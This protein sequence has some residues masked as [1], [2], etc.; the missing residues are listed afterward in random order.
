MAFKILYFNGEEISRY[1]MN[2][3]MAKDYEFKGIFCRRKDY[4][5]QKY[6][7]YI[8]TEDMETM[9]LAAEKNQDMHPSYLISMNANQLIKMSKFYMGI[10]K[11]EKNKNYAS[12]SWHPQVND[13]K[14][15]MLILT[16]HESS[17]GGNKIFND[18]ILIPKLGSSPLL[19]DVGKSIESLIQSTNV[20]Q[21]S[22]SS[23]IMAKPET[24]ENALI[25][26]VKFNGEVCMTFRQTYEDEFSISVLYPLSLY[27]A[28]SIFLSYID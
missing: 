21:L 11:L 15:V 16:R 12:Y 2:Q 17:S 1:M 7:Y 27:Q 28:F 24:N 18:E 26:S 6:R 23:E 13:S 25:H 19:L 10:F 3:P 9:L 5:T 20:L 4:Q 8:Y 14:R 22:G